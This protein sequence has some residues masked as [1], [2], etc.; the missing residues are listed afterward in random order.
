[1]KQT[2][3][4]N[5]FLIAMPALAD[6]DFVRSVTYICEHNEDG[7]LG[8]MINKQINIDLGELFRS[9]NIDTDNSP[10]DKEQAV[11]SGGPIHPEQGFVIHQPAGK[12]ASTLKT[13]DEI[14]IT[15]S[16]DIIEAVARQKGPD[17]YLVALGYAGWGGGQL[18]SELAANSW[19]SGPVDSKIIFETPVE[20][21]WDAAATLLGVDLSLLSSDIGHA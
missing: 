4:T 21:R 10:K 18:E 12:W 6:P 8:I 3:L 14:S 2:N 11:F 13:S 19:L 5:H 20:Q 15:T 7:A 16:R 9:M 17:S 1:M